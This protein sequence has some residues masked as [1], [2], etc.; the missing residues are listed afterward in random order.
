MEVTRSPGLQKD[1]E[2]LAR[3]AREKHSRLRA[4]HAGRFEAGMN[5]MHQVTRE[6]PGASQ[7]W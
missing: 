7:V 6:T 2:G 4:Q 5:W 3:P 1:E